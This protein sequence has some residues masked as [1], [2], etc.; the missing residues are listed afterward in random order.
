MPASSVHIERHVRHAA[1]C[2]S[3]YRGAATGDKCEARTIARSAG[4]K[5]T[6]VGWKQ[7]VRQMEAVAR[8]HEREMRASVRRSERQAMGTHREIVR[9]RREQARDAAQI[10]KERARQSAAAEADE[11]ASYVARLTS[12]HTDCSELWNWHAIAASPPPIAPV[13]QNAAETAARAAL[14][15]HSPGLIDKIFGAAKQQRMQLESALQRGIALDQQSHD[16]ALRHYN[17]LFNQWRYQLEL[18]PAVLSLHLGACRAALQYVGAFDDI[19][20]FGT[21]VTLDTITSNATSFTCAIEDQE[22]VP[23][24]EVKLSTSGKLLTKEIAAGRYWALYQDHV[25]SCALRIAREAYAVIPIERVIVNVRIARLD[26]S[27][28]HLVRP[29]ILAVHFTR[30]ALTRLNFAAIDPSESLKNFAHRM[31]FKKTSGFDPVENITSDEQW[32]TT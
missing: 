13:R 27:T 10:Q 32:I 31:K 22:I 21:H 30:A 16:A 1:F 17:T 7:F 14:D 8:R 18:A 29:T 20:E 2:C 12:V 9:Q 23:S 6:V 24:E 11:Y 19:E 28:G 4:R 26:P 15:A 5:E 3:H 25:A